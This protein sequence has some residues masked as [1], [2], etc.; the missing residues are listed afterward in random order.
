MWPAKDDAEQQVGLLPPERRVRQDRRRAP[1]EAARAS[2]TRGT[3]LRDAEQLPCEVLLRGGELPNDERQSDQERHDERRDR[4]PEREPPPSGQHDQ[5]HDP[6]RQGRDEKQQPA[7]G[8]GQEE[9]SQHERSVAKIGKTKAMGP[10]C[11]RRR[12]RPIAAPGLQLLGLTPRASKTD[13]AF[14][15]SSPRSAANRTCRRLMPERSG[16]GLCCESRRR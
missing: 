10:G 11:L 4:E 2:S 9:R 1:P 13:P 6:E 12:V 16:A 3:R 8:V 14:T 15:G 5:E 7:P